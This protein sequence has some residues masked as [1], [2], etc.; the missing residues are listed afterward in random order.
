MIDLLSALSPTTPTAAAPVPAS[1]GSPVAA[2]DFGQALGAFL[3][4]Q[5]APA[6]PS[7]ALQPTALRQNPADDGKDLPVEAA[8]DD[9]SVDPIAPPTWFPVP[10]PFVTGVPLQSGPDA[11]QP[12][13]DETVVTGKPTAPA[14]TV[15]IAAPPP[16]LTSTLRAATTLDAVIPAPRDPASVDVARTP[17]RVV[18]PAAQ[19]FIPTIAATRVRSDRGVPSVLID[20]ASISTDAAPVTTPPIVEALTGT[21]PPAATLERAVAAIVTSPPAGLPTSVPSAPVSPP[22]AAVAVP[23]PAAQAIFVSTLPQPAG[24]VF[25]AALAVAGSWRE[26]A[27]RDPQVDTAALSGPAAPIDLRE[28]AVVHATADS[29]HTALDLTQDSGLQ[30][31]ID[32]IE[33]LRDDMDSRDT[34]VRL[35]PDALGSIDVAVRQEGDRVHVRFTAEQDATRALIVEAQPRLT[36][37]AATRGIRIGDTSVATDTAGGGAT[38]QPRPAPTFARAPSAAPREDIESD[39]DHRLA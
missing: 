29:T 21:N 6:D 39:T 2:G 34:R 12:D 37:L 19:R 32:R 4:S 18:Q 7:S 8:K 28:R 10:V 15:G 27:S 5:D 1:G 23:D 33:L 13:A 22:P 26:R 24:R 16:G 35:V 30:R 3:D 17:G 38:P 20:V 31:M 11:P 9:N 14:P 25:A 36:E